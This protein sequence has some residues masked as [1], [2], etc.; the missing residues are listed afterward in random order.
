M[1]SLRKIPY[2]A[3]ATLLVTA[4]GPK[5]VPGPGPEL[6]APIQTAY[7]LRYV[8]IVKG[9]GVRAEPGRRVRVHYTGWLNNGTKFDSSYDRGQ[10][11]EFIL[12]TGRVITGWDTGLE[13]MQVGGKRRLLIPYQLAYGRR[14]VG[15]IPPKSDLTFDVELVG[16]DSVA[17]GG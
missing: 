15:Q 9:T 7:A 2:L 3:V 16:V 11:I 10:P 6:K 17:A 13:G 5:R 1:N 12:G 4:C 8:D 14:S